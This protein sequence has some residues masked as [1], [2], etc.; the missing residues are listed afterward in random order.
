MAG[1]EVRYPLLDALRSKIMDLKS[2]SMFEMR[3]VAESTMDTAL[4][5]LADQEAR[6]ETLERVARAKS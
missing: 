3:D 4:R 2:A 1:K 6:I 5:L